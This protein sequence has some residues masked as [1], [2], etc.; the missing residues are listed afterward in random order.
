MNTYNPIIKSTEYQGGIFAPRPKVEENKP[1]ILSIKGSTGDYLQINKGDEILLKEIRKKGYNWITEIDASYHAIEFNMEALSSNHIYSF[2]VTFRFNVRVT[3]PEMI[4]QYHITDMS[5][6][7]KESIEGIVEDFSRSLE[8]HQ[9]QELKEQIKDKFYPALELE[10]GVSLEFKAVVVDMDKEVRSQLKEIEDLKV[11]EMLRTKEAESANRI[12]DKYLDDTGT[13]VEI[14]KGKMSPEK[15]AQTRR[16]L[17][18]NKVNDQVERIKLYSETLRGL[19]DDRVISE[20][21]MQLSIKK[22]LS[23]IDADMSANRIIDKN[24]N[25]NEYTEDD[26]SSFD[27][28]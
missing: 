26:Y 24:S 27:E 2:G 22:M 11:L 12:R 25:E 3:K 15:L 21:D 23:G 7:V 9:I 14:L 13:L 10:E 28:E 6:Y 20:A 1:I 19:V 5:S 8:I 18:K 4:F 17:E 16:E